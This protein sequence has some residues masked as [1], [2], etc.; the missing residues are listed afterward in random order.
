MYKLKLEKFCHFYA[1]KLLRSA[2]KVKKYP[3]LVH[4]VNNFK[5]Y[6]FGDTCVKVLI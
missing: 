1:D 2:V 4:L 3:F 6:L 5:L